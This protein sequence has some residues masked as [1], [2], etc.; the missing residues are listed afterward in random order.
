[1][2]TSEKGFTREPRTQTARTSCR[3]TSESGGV[4]SQKLNARDPSEPEVKVCQAQAQFLTLHQ[5]Q[6]NNA[7]TA[8]DCHAKT[9][10]SV[11]VNFCAFS[12][13]CVFSKENRRT[14]K[15]VHKRCLLSPT[16]T[17]SAPI[18]G[19]DVL[20]IRVKTDSCELKRESC[21]KRNFRVLSLESGTI[22]GKKCPR[23]QG[24]RIW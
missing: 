9:A 2:V 15:R 8:A 24:E 21:Q 20:R 4:R 12:R 7:T 19:Q 18:A 22:C 16:A 5:A 13:G 1:M 3:Q 14:K 10:G 23:P 6:K 17:V 11:F